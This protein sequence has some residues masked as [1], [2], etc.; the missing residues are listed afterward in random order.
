M[1]GLDQQLGEIQP[2]AL[3]VFGGIYLRTLRSK[4][5]P[6][7]V[8]SHQS[9]LKKFV[10][11]CSTQRPL[12]ESTERVLSQFIWYLIDELELDVDTVVGHVYS[13]L[14]FCSCL[15]QESPAILQARLASELRA[16]SFDK[17]SW[18]ILVDEFDP[19]PTPEQQRSVNA[20]LTYLRKRQY[21]TRTHV[22]VEFVYETAGRPTQVR[23]LNLSDI[24]LD[25]QFATISISE[26]HVVATAGLHEDRTASL[27]STLIGPLRTYLE[28]EHETQP[29]NEHQPLF[30]TAHG[31]ASAGT[32]R[33][34]V[35]SA[36]NNAQ[37]YASFDP[38]TNCT[39]Q[40][41]PATAAT[42]VPSDI[43]RVAL[44][45]VVDCQ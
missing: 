28:H 35:R 27:S 45:E 9:S 30:T 26:N 39:E 38:E 4:T 19:Q 36:S 44:N 5:P 21:A 10:T 12:S 20:L 29:Q 17:S 25:Q 16:R 22:F 1:T 43:W 14:S 3:K 8:L 11:W 18:D 15:Y 41:T 2:S 33:K 32:L 6:T 37:E 31:R 34:G 40:G 23:A 13:L 7:T 42:V 24:Q